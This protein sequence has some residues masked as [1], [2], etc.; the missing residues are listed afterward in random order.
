MSNLLSVLRHE[1]KYLLSD[2]Q[3]HRLQNYFSNVLQSDT[4]NQAEGYLV[5]SL[6][7][8]T[9]D[10]RDYLDKLDG[11]LERRKLRLRMY[12]PEDKTVKLEL[13]QKS[14]AFQR[15]RSL[16]LTRMQAESLVQGDLGVLR[17]M[18]QP[19]AQEC[20]YLMSLGV[21]RP[22]CIVEYQRRAFV[23]AANDIRITFDTNVCATLSPQGFFEPRVFG[24][25]V[26]PFGNTIME[27][28]YNHFLLSYIKDMV[29][30]C[31][32]SAAAISKYCLARQ[33]GL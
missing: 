10:D 23:A 16:V 24:I 31:D 27:V 18:E 2:I 29:S 9:P 33:I 28:K 4:H 25:P 1:T 11:L 5:R 22:K 17:A 14:G 19:F 6:Y 21:Y 20:L 8:D 3:Y 26:I 13:K 12:S 7:F 15:K 30:Q 32:T